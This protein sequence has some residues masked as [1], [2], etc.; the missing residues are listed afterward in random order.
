[1]SHHEESPEKT[2]YIIWQPP[3]SFLDKHHSPRLPYLPFSGKNFQTPISINFRN[4]DPPPPPS[5][6]MKVGGEGGG[7]NMEPSESILSYMEKKTE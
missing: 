4:G 3:L 6:F 5:P 7:P 1:M 2:Q